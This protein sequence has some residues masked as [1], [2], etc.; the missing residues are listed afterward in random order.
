MV[1]TTEKSVGCS[2]ILNVFPEGWYSSDYLQRA[3]IIRIHRIQFSR[4]PLEL[5]H[6]QIQRPRQPRRDIFRRQL[7][8]QA[9]H[10]L[11]IET[12]LP[13]FNRGAEISHQ[14]EIALPNIPPERIWVFGV[15]GNDIRRELRD[16]VPCP[17]VVP[18]RWDSL[19]AVGR[20]AAAT[21]GLGA[22]E[23]LHGRQIRCALETVGGK[24]L[25]KEG[26]R[27]EE[28]G[29]FGPVVEVWV[30]GSG[31]IVSQ[32]FVVCETITVEDVVHGRGH[33]REK[34]RVEGVVVA[35]EEIVLAC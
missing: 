22:E 12:E 29:T 3:A 14:V 19:S 28:E 25:E 18:V 34:R 1:A 4:H 15:H 24:G 10:I 16:R 7:V 20:K 31:L 35:G 30:V 17:P 26:G 5:L 21:D 2:I 23:G 33:Q 8:K 32:G 13:T 6:T 11:L 9:L 27:G